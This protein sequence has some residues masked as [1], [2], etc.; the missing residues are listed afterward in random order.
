VPLTHHGSFIIGQILARGL[1]LQF[2]S[3]NHAPSGII[4]PSGF[5]MTDASY[6]DFTSA[7]GARLP[8]RDSLPVSSRFKMTQSGHRGVTPTSPARVV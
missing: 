3:L 6:P 1:S 5:V 8:W 2:G 4:N 7:F